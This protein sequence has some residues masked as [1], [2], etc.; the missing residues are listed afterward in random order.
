M[1]FFMKSLD[2]VVIFHCIA[3]FSE[4]RLYL[5]VILTLKKKSFPLVTHI[6]SSAEEWM[7]IFDFHYCVETLTLKR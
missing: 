2:Y 5:I 4:F 7:V 6:F 3:I 1:N